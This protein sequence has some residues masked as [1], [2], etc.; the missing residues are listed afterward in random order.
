[1]TFFFSRRSVRGRTQFYWHYATSSVVSPVRTGKRSRCGYSLSGGGSHFAGPL[2]RSARGARDAVTVRHRTRKI[3][4]IFTFDLALGYKM[5]KAVRPKG[6]T[7]FHHASSLMAPG[8]IGPPKREFSIRGSL[9]WRIRKINR[10]GVSY[11]H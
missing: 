8:G 10:L 6:G 7:A 9:L 11:M 1:M 5:K 4:G 3:G 2:E